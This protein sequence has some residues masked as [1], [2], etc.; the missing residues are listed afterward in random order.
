VN[1]I[2]VPILAWTLVLSLAAIWG[3]TYSLRHFIES[4]A[5]RSLPKL[6]GQLFVR[7]DR[8]TKTGRTLWLLRNGLVVA[9]LLLWMF[10]WSLDVPAAR[11]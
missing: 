11:P 7:K 6:T 9:V 3:I 2:V 1:T 5:K 4:D 8:L 10:L